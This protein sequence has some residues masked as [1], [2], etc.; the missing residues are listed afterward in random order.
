V[1]SKSKSIQKALAD[2]RKALHALRLWKS[3]PHVL[4]DRLRRAQASLWHP[5]MTFE[6][7]QAAFVQRYNANPCN[8]LPAHILYNFYRLDLS[9]RKLEERAAKWIKATNEERKKNGLPLIPWSPPPANA[10]TAPK[11]INQEGRPS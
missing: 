1:G 8:F 11:I 9:Q 6:R 2:W 5:E 10:V 3:P 7:R 4:V